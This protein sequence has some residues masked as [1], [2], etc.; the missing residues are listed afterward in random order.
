VGFLA[1]EGNGVA[2]GLDAID[3]DFTDCV[4]AGDAG[5]GD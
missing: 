5:V 3:V 4:G 1:G 2:G